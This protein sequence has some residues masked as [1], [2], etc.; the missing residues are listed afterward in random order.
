MFVSEKQTDKKIIGGQRVDGEEG[1]KGQEEMKNR[2]AKGG[3]KKEQENEGGN[4]KQENERRW[5]E[6]TG[7]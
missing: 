6:R 3:G 7:E 1:K 5:R 4:E 2:R